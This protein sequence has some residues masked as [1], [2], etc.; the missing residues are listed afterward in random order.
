MAAILPVIFFI[1]SLKSTDADITRIAHLSLI[2]ERID[3]AVRRGV[4]IPLPTNALELT[5]G[6]IKMG[7][8]GRAGK[9]LFLALGLE[10]LK[11]PETGET[12]HYFIRPDTKDYE[13]VTTLSDSQYANF[14]I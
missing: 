12:Y 1:T 11:D 4:N 6:E 3:D 5:F 8:Q 7:Y 2:K 10:F 9:D 14:K 13:I